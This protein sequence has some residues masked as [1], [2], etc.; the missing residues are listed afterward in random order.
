MIDLSEELVVVSMSRALRRCADLDDE[1]AR[2]R[3]I[4]N[5]PCGEA[6]VLLANNR[7]VFERLEM[8]AVGYERIRRER[9]F[10]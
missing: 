3:A 9:G 2:L 7:P 4:E 8:R 1:D 6:L 10:R 5:G